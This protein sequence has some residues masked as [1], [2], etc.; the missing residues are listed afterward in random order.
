MMRLRA[1]QF[2]IQRRDY[3]QVVFEEKLERRLVSRAREL[4]HS[5]AEEA[6][7]SKVWFGLMGYATQRALAASP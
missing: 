4:L 1:T 7:Q 2:A 6:K 5:A 3:C